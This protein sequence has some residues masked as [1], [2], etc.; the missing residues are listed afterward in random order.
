ML[1]NGTSVDLLIGRIG[2]SQAVPPTTLV[3]DAPNLASSSGLFFNSFHEL[4]TAENVNDCIRNLNIDVA[5]L[6]VQLAKMKKDSALEVLNKVFD[7]NVLANYPTSEG[8]VSTN[9]DVD[10]Y[11]DL[12]AS[13]LGV[14]DACIGY[15][16]SVKA[17]QLFITSE[18][19]NGTQRKMKAA[20]PYLKA[21]LEGINDTDGNTMSSGANVQ[22][23][24]SIKDAIEV[25]FP[26]TSRNDKIFLRDK[27]NMW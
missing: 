17:L 11:D 1:Y 20:Y 19:S 24:R 25:L 10:G 21:E 13:K 22:F 23:T 27:T 8:V 9:Y 16:M 14:F 12:I 6:N 2:W 18:R 26:T 5:N 15:S 7:L 4:V 3:V